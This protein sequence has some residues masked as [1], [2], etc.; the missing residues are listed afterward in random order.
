MS[1]GDSDLVRQ[2]TGR[3]DRGKAMGFAFIEEHRSSWAVSL[4]AGVLAVSVSG[5]YDGLWLG[6]S[7]RAVDD[8]SPT[9]KFVMW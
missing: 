9:E 7:K 4:M 5:F 8:E 6:K 1:R 2:E 3:I